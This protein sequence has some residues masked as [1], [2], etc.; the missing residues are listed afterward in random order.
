MP[1]RQRSAPKR[2]SSSSSEEIKVLRKEL[3]AERAARVK[4]EARAQELEW[5]VES[6]EA[7]LEIFRK[8]HNAE[9]E[10]LQDE[11][12]R[13]EKAVADRD[14]LLEQVNAQLTWFRENFLSPNRSE[15]DGVDGQ[16]A[17]EM[18]AQDQ[19]GQTEAETE[20]PEAGTQGETPAETTKRKRGQQRGTKGPGRSDRS[21]LRTDTEFI[22]KRGC[23]CSK[24]GKA[25]RRLSVTKQSPLIE[26]YTEL[27]RILHERFTYVPDCD[28]EGNKPITADP[29]AKL[30]DR[31][32]IGNTVWA[33]VIA[34]KYLYGEPTE[35][36]LKWCSLRHLHLSK[37]TVTGGLKVVNEKLEFLY[38]ALK[39]HCRGAD[40]WNGDETWWSL[41]GKR[42]WMWMVASKDA[43]V[44]LLDPSR[45][46]KVPNDFFAGSKGVFMTDRL[47]SYK[48][49]P[50]DIR[51][52][53]CWV[54]QRRDFLNVFK[55]M[56][57]LKEWAEAWLKRIA[58]LF[59]LNHKRF[60]A[61]ENNQQ[62]GKDFDEA[63]KLVDEH[64]QG[65]KECFESELK[66][67]GLHKKQK[68][69]LESMK[70]HWDGLTL[71]LEDPRIPLDN[72]RAERLLRNAVLL[73]KNSYGSGAQWAGEFAAKV[74][75]IFQTW[76][77]NGLD[78]EALLLDY[79]NECSKPGRPPPDTKLFLPWTMSQARK[80]QFALPK[81]YKRPG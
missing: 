2:H 29:P 4:A 40:F 13:L 20:V 54:H 75:S 25:Y 64:V 5:K 78:P 32:E 24:C 42:W 16:A 47:A 53:W 61:W 44:Y 56:P 57:K 18:R 74:F 65:L 21:Q 45:S 11:I 30:Y 37:G 38:Q 73:R 33:Y 70:R 9:R 58:T 69:I 76:L 34:R 63:Q 22:E 36:T 81:T 15:R 12:R 17:E 66:Q 43:V 28:C 77:I 39:N 7:E 31:T 71:F 6:L 79:L 80:K 68:T 46:K 72:N 51:K 23:A 52:A 41:F 62:F 14:E 27:V 48:G 49:L 35:R 10:F 19:P 3:K 50:D 1:V 55:G 60:K 8:N 59:V 67:S 26:L